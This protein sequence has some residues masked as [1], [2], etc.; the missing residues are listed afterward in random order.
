VTPFAIP[1]RERALH[2]LI[3][4]LARFWGDP[5][6]RDRPG[7]GPPVALAQRIRQVLVER[8]DAVDDDEVS[9]T[10][11]MIDRI[12]G[13]WRRLPPFRYGDFA[14]PDP[15]VP[16]MYPSGSQPLPVWQDRA[17]A[18]PSSLRNV[19]SECDAKVLTRFSPD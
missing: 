2:A 3:V 16:L 17:R 12:M 11:A 5:S 13:E 8:A 18:T 7:A 6:L 14:P 4:A 10:E 1:V 9:E 15:T 19:D